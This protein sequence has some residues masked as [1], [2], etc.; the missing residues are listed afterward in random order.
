[1]RFSVS[2]VPSCSYL[3]CIWLTV[4]HNVGPTFDVQ[5][6]M[7]F[8]CLPRFPRLIILSCFLFFLDSGAGRRLPRRIH[9]RVTG[10]RR[11]STIFLYQS[12]SLI[13]VV[14]VQLRI[15]TGD[16]ESVIY[17]HLPTTILREAVQ[18]KYWRARQVVVSSPAGPSRTP[19]KIT[20]RYPR[21]DWRR[22]FFFR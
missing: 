16:G 2:T 5:L 21:C 18:E 10:T 11:K 20:T 1:M 3:N 15:M 9:R 13:D 12:R 7:L 4:V 17:S 19:K 8:R 14:N 6:T 22:C